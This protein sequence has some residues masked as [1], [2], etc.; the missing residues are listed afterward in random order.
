MRN[1]G[2][3]VISNV[4]VAKYR[5]R[6]RPVRKGVDIAKVM[7]AAAKRGRSK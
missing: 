2:S 5:A 7:R 6:T 1:T 3:A 4:K